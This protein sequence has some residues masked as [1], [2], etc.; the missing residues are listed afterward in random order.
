MLLQLNCTCAL[1]ASLIQDA[2]QDIAL[3]IVILLLED[4]GC[5]LNQE[6]GQLSL[7]ATIC[8]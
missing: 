7:Q 5:D 6:T 1:H 2:V 8:K 4:Q 3:L